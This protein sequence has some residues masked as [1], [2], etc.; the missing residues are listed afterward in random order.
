VSPET[1][2]DR[3]ERWKASGL[4]AK[5][6]AAAEDIS[7]YS[8]SWW[9]WRLHR[10]GEAPAARTATRKPKAKPASMSFVPVVVRDAPATPMDVILPGDVRVRVDAGFDEASLLRLVRALASSASS[11]SKTASRSNPSAPGFSRAKARTPTTCSS[12]ATTSAA[13][14]L[15]SSPASQLANQIQ[16]FSHACGY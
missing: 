10:E 9:R 6:L 16:H 15:A 11:R 8:L 13:S 14:M 7:P 5:E 2:K 12:T 1:W 3:V 4:G